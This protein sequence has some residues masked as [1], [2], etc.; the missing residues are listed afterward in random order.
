MSMRIQFDIPDELWERAKRYILD[1]KARHIFGR[2]ALEEWVT[3]HEGRDKKLQTERR[4][5]DA[6]ALRD[7]FI[8]L[9]DEIHGRTP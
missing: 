3:R 7:V 5:A 4:I 6:E 8:K 9:H 1:A 2:I